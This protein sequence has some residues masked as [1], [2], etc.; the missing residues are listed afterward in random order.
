ML[1]L[2]TA[3][4][5]I[6]ASPD[7]AVIAI[8][9]T[10]TELTA[11]VENQSEQQG[12][13]LY[14]QGRY[15]EA[16]QALQQALLDYENDPVGQ[17]TVLSNLAL[18]YQQLGAWAEAK[19]AIDRAINLLQRQGT[20]ASSDL[21]PVLA[22]ALD[23]RGSLQLS[24]GQAE[25]ALKTWEQSTALHQQTGNQNAAIRA[26]INQAEALQTLGLYRRA[27]EQL[28]TLRKTMQSQPDSPEKAASLRNLG[29]ALLV[30][31]SSV[32]AKDVLNESLKIAQTIQAPD[33]IAAAY[34]SLGNLARSNALTQ[35]RLG[36]D[37]PAQQA[38][39][40]ALE[41][42]QKAASTNTEIQIEAQLNRLRFLTD[43]GRWSE[44]QT[45]YTTVMPQ[46]DRLPPGRNAIYAQVNL[47]Q[48]LVK[49]WHRSSNRATV[50]LTAIAKML[51]QARQQAERLQ[52]RRAQAYVLGTL[53][54]LY[55]QTKQGDIA[56]ALTRQALNLAHTIQAED[57]AYQW[58]WQIGRLL[59]AENDQP[60]AIEA[61]DSAFNSLQLIRRDLVTLNP[62]AQFAFRE[63]VEPI[64]RQYVDLLL[65]S[66]TPPQEN[67][68]KSR[69]VI[70]SLQIAELENFFQQGCLGNTLQLDDVVNQSTSSVAAIYSIILPKRLE[71]IAKLPGQKDLYHYPPTKIDEEKVK[72][73]LKQLQLDLQE[74]Y[75][76]EAVK[77]S[78]KQ[79]YDWLIAPLQEQL[80]QQQIKTLAFVLDGTLRT[81]PMA[82]LYDGN[83]YLME[84]YAVS[85]V[86]GLTIQ[87]PK[88]LP[89][90]DRLAVLAGS[91]SQPPASFKDKFSVLDN[92]TPEVQQISR[93]GLPTKTLEEFT[94]TQ[95]VNSL[96]QTP[97]QI[98]HLATHGQ[99]SFDRKDTFLLAADK[100]IVVDDLSNIFRVQNSDGTAIELL[101]L[102]ACE[103]ATGDDRS[104][105]GIA[106]ATVR[107]G[108]R[109]TIASLWSLDDASGAQFMGELYKHLGKPNITR[110]EALRL[111]QQ[112][113]S[114]TPEYEHPRYWAP[115]ILVG[116]WL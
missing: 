35:R 98:V 15:T 8:P 29:N 92:V 33:A 87:D 58:E 7:R 61:Y 39:Q 43:L 90:R 112:A 36:N 110:A 21:A 50:N 22:Q 100:K 27:I 13:R 113:L 78:S 55:E 40:E 86:L 101:I 51:A 1:A 19:D 57:I 45:L 62:D 77:Q 56:Q 73:H 31:G 49:L 54:N 28:S 47:A 64:Y 83:A 105:L 16:V 97:F 115:Y 20:A 85:T 111:A 26:Q 9:P 107:A 18:T 103:T 60:G 3:C 2:F 84:K 37:T 32:D 99:F 68:D 79:V 93:S 46:I 75:T 30:A 91:V 42:Y 106:G 24:Q 4:L 5:C 109:S 80:E 72:K 74:A 102:S 76:Y 41:A 38:T 44:A 63:N 12:R 71:V 14:E 116:S 69:R 17:A 67:L 82:A 10:S 48:S 25:A 104:V 88:P 95:F 70:E 34:L 114:Q 52:D 89:S 6:I 66:P 108:A 94:S 23:V 53:G 96:D 11:P 59:E 65:R 81:I